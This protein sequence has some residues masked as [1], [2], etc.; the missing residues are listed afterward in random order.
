[1]HDFLRRLR[2][3]VTKEMKQLLRDR[4]SLLIG[5]VIPL[6]LLFLI[7]YGLSMDVK[8]LPTAVVLEDNS[9]T[10]QQL[11]SSLRGSEY[12]SPTYVTNMQ[13]AEQLML[14]R[15]V[16]AILVVPPN[17]TESVYQGRGEVQVII[18]GIETS[19]TSAKSYVQAAVGQWY[20][21]NASKLALNGSGKGQISVEQR[22]WFND[23]NTSTWYFVPGIIVIVLSLVGVFLTS[24]VMA[25]EWERGT[26]EALFITP[27]K[28]LE[29]ILAKMIPYFLVA[30]VGWTLSLLASR[31]VFEVPLYGSLPMLLLASVVYLFVM[32]GMGL[33]ISSVVRSQFIACQLSMMVSMLPTMLLSGFIYDL[34]NVPKVINM[35]GHVMPATYYL[36]IVKNI[37]LAGNNWPLMLK[38]TA[39]L[40]GYAIFFVGMSFHVTR[41]KVE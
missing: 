12:I 27:V 21:Q 35:I 29:I 7:G 14:Q 30:M 22:I 5:I 17:F 9:P 4:S 10:A 31:Y 3:L 2:A 34:R 20:A 1:M 25:K 36:E 41:K 13:E 37:F 11:T 18:Y 26:L 24:L 38:N 28:V 23:A 40:V 16:D 6:M 32:L 39:I 8:H 33:T 15:R 19:A